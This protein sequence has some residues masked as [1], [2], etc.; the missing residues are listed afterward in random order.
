MS[1]AVWTP[2]TSPPLTR[3]EVRHAVDHG[4]VDRAVGVP[5]ARARQIGGMEGFDIG[6]ESSRPDIGSLF[7]PIDGGADLK[8]DDI[9]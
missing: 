2:R 6:L 9:V 1:W 3:H 4:N 8:G 5:S 7:P